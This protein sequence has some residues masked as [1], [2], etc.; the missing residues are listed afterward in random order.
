M[1]GDHES[2]LEFNVGKEALVA[3]QKSSADVRREGKPDDRHGG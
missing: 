1:N 3:P 2:V